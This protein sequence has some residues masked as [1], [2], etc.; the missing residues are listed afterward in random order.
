MA[1]NKEKKTKEDPYLLNDEENVEEVEKKTVSIYDPEKDKPE[2]I[3]KA[4]K[5]A[6]DDKVKFAHDGKVLRF[7]L[8]KTKSLRLKILVKLICLN[9]KLLVYLKKLRT[10]L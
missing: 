1:K 6:D 10:Q 5:R 9:Q 3:L 4:V 2:E 7:R 8:K